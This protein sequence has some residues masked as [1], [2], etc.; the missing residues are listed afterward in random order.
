MFCYVDKDYDVDVLNKQIAEDIDGFISECENFYKAQIMSA[1]D[2]IIAENRTIVLLSGPSGSGKTTTSGKIRDEL[3]RRGKISHVV[4]LDDFYLN[5]DDLPIVDGVQNAEVVEALDLDGI[6]RAMREVVTEDVV[7]LPHYD[8]KSGIRTDN[9][10]KIEIGEDGIVIFEG[11][12]ALNERIMGHADENFRFGIYVSPHS[13]FT[14]DGELFMSKRDVR[15]VRRFVRDSWS[16]GTDPEGTYAM[17]GMV[18]EGEDKFIRPCAKFADIHINSTHAYEPGLI[19]AMAIELLEKVRPESDFYEKATEIIRE[20]KYFDPIQK[21]KLPET[22][23]LR[24]FV[25]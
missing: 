1:C 21:N 7:W 9:A 3:I 15:F 25:G 6:D 4:S 13:G 8:F 10:Q 24:E 22:S 17:W 20:L 2:H 12:H 18:C 5:R 23:L 11:I 14:K 16:R 19:A